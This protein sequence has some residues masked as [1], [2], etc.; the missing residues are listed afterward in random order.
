MVLEASSR[1]RVASVGTA[2]HNG[3]GLA[4]QGCIVASKLSIS[5]AWDQTRDIFRRDGSLIVAVALALIVLP[6]VVVGILA[7]P[8]R[9]GVDPSSSAQLLRLVAALV[10][11]IGQ[12]AIIR[13]ALGPSTTVRA[14]INH[15]LRRFPSAFGALVLM[16]LALAVVLIPLTATLSVLLGVD[17]AQL[18]QAPSGSASLLVL[19]LVLVVLLISVRFTLLMAVASAEQLGPIGIIKRT[20]KLTSGHFLR[21]LGLVAL[22]LVAVIVLLATASVIGGLAARL[23][24]PTIEPL[25]VSALLIALIAGAAQGVFSILASVM[26]ARVYTQVAGR[27]VEAS[28]PSTGD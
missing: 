10:S 26:L 24:S 11:L 6:E 19:L 8:E 23:I 28:V 3:R 5:R 14:A 4:Q 12:M 7:P 20:W 1:K 27:D 15:G 17:L 16:V 25:S 9:S 21:L 13:L 18:R 2:T 22:L